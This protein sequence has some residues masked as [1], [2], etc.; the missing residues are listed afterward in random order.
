METLKELNPESKQISESS[1]HAVRTKQQRGPAKKETYKTA[2]A[3]KQA[4]KEK[5]NQKPC[6]RCGG[7]HGP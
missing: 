2:V 1:V 7:K 3:S 4:S 5:T 6:G